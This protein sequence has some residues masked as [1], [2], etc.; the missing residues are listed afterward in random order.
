MKSEHR[1]ELETNSLASS[2]ASLPATIKLHGNKILTVLAIVLL[3][4]AGIRYKRSQ[5]EAAAQAVRQ[6]LATAWTVIRNIQG[7][8]QQPV[9]DNAETDIKA[10][11]QNVID[12]ADASD[13]AQ[14]ANAYQALGQLYWTLAVQSPIATTGPSTQP[15]TRPTNYFDLS[16]DAYQKVISS[17]P[18]QAQSVIASRFALAA[19]AE[20]KHEWAAAREQYQQ[21]IES[22]KALPTDKALAEEQISSLEKLENPL[23]LI[24]A[25]QPVAV[26]PTTAPALTDFPSLQIGPT[27]TTSPSTV[28]AAVPATA[29]TTV[30]AAAPAT[31]APTTT[32]AMQPK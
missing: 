1:H 24:P 18:D 21:V 4:V 32:P 11:V 29:P 13:H 23:L 12:T 6:S 17:Y 26:E 19:I 2:L 3:V 8:N 25:S 27:P 14:L 7:V 30:P 22:D 5:D 16:R 20:E 28:P 9:L 15:T 10:A 31:T